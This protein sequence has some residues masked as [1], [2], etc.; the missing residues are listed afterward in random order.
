MPNL[1][2]KVSFKGTK[3]QEKEL[4]DFIR[5]HSQDKGSMMPILQKAQEMYG[6]IP[7]EVQI[8]IAEE[9]G[10]PLS[11][12]YGIVSFY[13]QFTLNPKGKYQISVCLGTAC[14]VKGAGDI[15][16]KVCEII[17]CESGSITDDG[18]FSVDATRC[19][20]ACGLAP[21]FTVNESVYGRVDVAETEQ[22]I[23]KYVAEAKGS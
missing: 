4:V 10:V 18:M 22:I 20:G 13:S 16:D 6:Y 8:I 1:K 23:Q 14:Y 12:I 3:E 11:E 2:T 7:E 9:T 15:L 21:V 17:G 19:I 5:A